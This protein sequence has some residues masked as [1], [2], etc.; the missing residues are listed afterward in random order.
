MRI[1]TVIPAYNR[2]DLIGE[3]LRTVL[4][5]A[6]PPH[7]VIVVDD[8]S[9]DGTADVVAGFGRDVT[10]VRQA[11]AGPAAARNAGFARSTGEIV[12]FM[13]SDDL[14]SLNTYAAQAA[15]IER[16]AD[17][18]Y[19]PWAKA[20]IGDGEVA[21]E[22]FVLQQGPVPSG[23]VIEHQI[24]LTYWATI[25]QACLFRRS[26]IERTGPF[27]TDLNP[28]DDLEKLYRIMR[29]RPQVSHLADT[30][31]LYRVH[32]HGQ[33]TGQDSPGRR[34]DW[35]KVMSLFQQY[36]GERADV[37][38][39]TRWL[40]RLKRL[41]RALQAKDDAPRPAGLLMRDAGPLDRQLVR[42]LRLC[43]RALPKAQ[44]RLGG[45]PY[46]KAF[47]PGPLRARQRE[48]IAELGYRLKQDGHD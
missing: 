36:I 27:R 7:E 33:L 37:P 19:G 34:I 40:F 5:Q 38:L 23:I 32:P 16:G 15:A 44:V 42:A 48:L 9:S 4:S 20:R 39:R 8:G 12:H 41:D 13:D 22:E 25:L 1:S 30:V 47:Q 11:N 18:V 29:A 26:V 17:M 3:T 10:L 46:S 2:A 43:E 28:S 24:L 21:L 31:L 45:K 14:L 35:V 6:R